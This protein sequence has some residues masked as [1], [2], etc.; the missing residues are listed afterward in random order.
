MES[1]ND[2]LQNNSRKPTIINPA[3]PEEDLA[4][5]WSDN[6]F[7]SFKANFNKAT[8]TAREA[9]ESSDYN[10]S[11]DLWQELFSDRF[12]RIK[13]PNSPQ[14]PPGGNKPPKKPGNRGPRE[15]GNK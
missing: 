1:L 5:R 4:E 9:L 14:I 8:Q 12:P 2:W 10:D 11:V 3:L 6:G 13:K 15:Y 7:S